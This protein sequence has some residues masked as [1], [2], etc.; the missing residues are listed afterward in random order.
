MRRRVSFAAA[1][2]G[3]DPR[4]TDQAVTYPV[5]AGDAPVTLIV[6]HDKT[7]WSQT[8]YCANRAEALKFLKKFGYRVRVPP[9]P[10]QA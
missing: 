9:D 1:D 7:G 6:D 5:W 4:V 3:F 8:L 2:L 10:G